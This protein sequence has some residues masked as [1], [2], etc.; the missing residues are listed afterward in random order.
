MVLP[1]DLLRVAYGCCI[2]L[3]HCEGC[4]Q[5]GIHYDPRR[6]GIHHFLGKDCQVV[7]R[8]LS[9][10]GLP[11]SHSPVPQEHGAQLE[12]PHLSDHKLDRSILA[13]D[14]KNGEGQ[15]VLP[16]CLCRLV[17]GSGLNFSD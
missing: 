15:L 13:D 14:L 7:W 9:E 8:R 4:G 12:E 1:R 16:G 5:E 10:G 3:R 11:A 6:V 2:D 17:D